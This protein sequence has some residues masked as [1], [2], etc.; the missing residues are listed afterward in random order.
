M[1]HFTESIA[2]AYRKVRLNTGLHLDLMNG[3]RMGYAVYPVK[4]YQML[5]FSRVAGTRV[6]SETL[7]SERILPSFCHLFI[8]TTD[9][10]IG[11]YS[12]RYD[13]I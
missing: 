6:I 10:R 13:I 3:L 8:I 12:L 7:F 11:D 4:N 9:R 5:E 2:L 1:H